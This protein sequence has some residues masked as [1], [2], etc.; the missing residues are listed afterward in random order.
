MP[1][2]LNI[3]PTPGAVKL[4]TYLKANRVPLV[5]VTSSSRK[6]FDVKAR[7]NKDLL[8]M[9]DHIICSDDVNNGKPELNIFIK[10]CEILENPPPEECLIF[11]DLINGVIATQKANMRVIWVP[12]KFITKVDDVVM[13][14]LD[15]KPEKFKLLPFDMNL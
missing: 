14:L 5:I 11:K 12:N 13:S 15:F 9:F 4:I 1:K 6:N 2:F 10:A 3:K 8:N 7:K